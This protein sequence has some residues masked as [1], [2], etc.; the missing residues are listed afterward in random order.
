M[1][2]NQGNRHIKTERG[3]VNH[4]TKTSKP[5]PSYNMDRE[6]DFL[7]HIRV[8]FAWV[9][10][11]Y[12]LTRGEIEL[13]LF[14]HKH[15]VFT[16][17]QI[18]DYHKL[19]SLFPQKTLGKYIEDKWIKEWFTGEMKSY[20]QYVLSKKGTKLCSDMHRMCVGDMDIPV[21]M[22]SKDSSDSGGGKKVN[23]YYLNEIEKIN[24]ENIGRDARRKKFNN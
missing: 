8:V 9:R 5:L 24:K 4:K 12:S 17:N 6:Y 10:E 22:G 19:I 20:T 7:T 23:E 18:V 1:K 11:N 15:K 21:K 14:L 16:K 3:Y 2:N 13:L